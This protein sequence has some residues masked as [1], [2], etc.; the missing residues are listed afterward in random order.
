E[1]GALSADHLEASTEKEIAMLA[2]SNTVS[3]VL[4]GASLGLG[5]QYSP[6]RKLLDAGACVAIA[7]DWNPG[8]APMGNLLM[9]A[10]VMAAA[11]KLNNAEV[12]AG[13]NPRAAIT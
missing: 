12:F 10:S 7:S 11:E 1:V 3:V 2:K 8:S 4:P 13:F 9:Q 5:M 6:A